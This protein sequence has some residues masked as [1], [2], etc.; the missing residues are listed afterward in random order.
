MLM[1]LFQEFLYNLTGAIT[2]TL[3]SIC[4]SLAVF[5]LLKKGKLLRVTAEHEILGKHFTFK[6][7]KA[8]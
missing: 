5:T 1:H 8:S 3:W 7:Y 4:I 2:I 6:E